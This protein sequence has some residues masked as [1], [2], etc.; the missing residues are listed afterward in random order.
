MTTKIDRFYKHLQMEEWKLSID[1]THQMLQ[2]CKGIS[3]EK[4]H[5]KEGVK[6]W[7]YVLDEVAFGREPEIE[8]EVLNFKPEREENDY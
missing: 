5:I 3:R 8:Q 2:K 7:V 6:K 4:F 1:L